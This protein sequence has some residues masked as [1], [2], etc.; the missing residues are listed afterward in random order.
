[1]LWG[2]RLD[3]HGSDDRLQPDLSPRIGVAASK[4]TSYHDAPIGLQRDTR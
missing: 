4:V 2:L 3:H 1:M